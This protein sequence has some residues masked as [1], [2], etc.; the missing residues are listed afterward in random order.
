MSN[1]YMSKIL[2]EIGTSAEPL[3]VSS[4]SEPSTYLQFIFIY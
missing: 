4:Y 3:K 1:I 2:T